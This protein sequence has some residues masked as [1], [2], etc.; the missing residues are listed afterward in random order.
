MV[1]DGHAKG[2][3]IVIQGVDLGNSMTNVNIRFEDV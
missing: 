1:F 3:A 2:Q